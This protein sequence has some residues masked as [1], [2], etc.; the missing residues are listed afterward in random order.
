ME[1]F[2]GKRILPVT[3]LSQ[4]RPKADPPPKDDA[5]ATFKHVLDSIRRY[6][7]FVVRMIAL[8]ALLAVLGSL[9]M[10][11]SYI[12]TAQLVVNARGGGA[13]DNAGAA[14]N[15][16]APAGGSDDSTIDT[17]VTVM[18]SDA[19]LR[20]LLPALRMLDKPAQGRV[21]DSAARA[22]IR[23]AWSK[24]KGVL[25]FGRHQP[26]DGAAV[27][28][29]KGRLKISQERR[30]RVISVIFNDANP[31]RAAEVANLVARS[32]VDELTRQKQAVELQALDTIAEQSAAVQRDLSKAKAEL[33]SSHSGPTSSSQSVAALEWQITTLA[34]QYETLLRRRQELT[35]KGVVTEPEVTVIADA[36]P[37][38]LPSSL[39][40][41]LLVPPITIIFA[42]LACLV[43]V[44][45]NHFDRSLHTEAEAA[46]ALGIPCVGLIP[47][48]P[49][50]L[51]SSPRRIVEQSAISHTRAVRST[52]VSLLATD[53]VSPRPQ[54]V[55]LVTSSLHGEGKSAVAW[56]FGSCAAQ[57]GQRV[58]FLD[59]G[60]LPRRP[61]GD[62][63]DLFKLLAHDEAAAK[64]VQ[65]IPELGV[66]YISAGLSEGNRLW[67]LAGPKVSS[68]FEQLRNTYDLIVINAPSLHDA[69]EVRLLA[70][71]ADHVL[72]AVRAGSTSRDVAQ[73]ALNRFARSSDLDAG[74]RFWCVLTHGIQS[75][76]TPSD[77][78]LSSKSPLM[79][80]YH[81]LKT[82]VARWIRIEPVIDVSDHAGAGLRPPQ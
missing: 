62:A 36:S 25:S 61:G 69:P 15:A 45:L 2:T 46:E 37:P 68:L 24:T 70:S 64:A 4:T 56:S 10:S 12:A 72:L 42:L 59:F 60:Q 79:L 63:A 81:R 5:V 1:A 28:A 73:S 47:S 65:H 43:A 9:L 6:K 52:V 13:A 50:E 23:T 58:L 33:D 39:N 8:G 66:D 34:Q 57:L 16:S 26:S 30:S 77:M 7:H 17:H 20:R 18:S 22:L 38:D 78:E 82:T 41:F 80:Y 14:G 19:Y 29:L 32:Y 71:W 27:A 54:H 76:V 21:T 53:P 74:V 11:P 55:V 31:Q 35:T 75:E 44:I 40:P 3:V 49:L 48:I 67:P 51:N